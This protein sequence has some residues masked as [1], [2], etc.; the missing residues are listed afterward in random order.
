MAD[1][2][3]EKSPDYIAA[4][5]AYRQFESQ[6]GVNYEPVIEYARELFDRS[7]KTDRLLDEK[8]DSIIKYLGGGSALVT[9][10]ALMSIKADSPNACLMGVVAL[11]FLI[12]SLVCAV[13]AVRYAI[14]VRMPRAS[15][16][17]P[18][19]DFAVKMA[20]F[21]KDKDAIQLNLFLILSPICEAAVH[22]NI[23]KSKGVSAAHRAYA[24]AMGLLILP[25]LAMAIC[26][27]VLWAT[28]VPLGTGR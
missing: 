5:Q 6:E 28:T 24:W 4:L 19:V 8:A 10:G 7:E 17:P 18:N 12:P 9:F 23:Q 25:V 2:D 14:M 11:V 16:M 3:Y 13:A 20:E 15:A 26:L 27:L 1:D 22:R 21:Y